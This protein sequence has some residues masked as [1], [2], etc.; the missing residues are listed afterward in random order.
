MASAQ[1][2]SL[3]KMIAKGGRTIICSIHTPSAR[4]FSTFDHVYI[5]AEGQCVYAGL[6]DDVVPFLATLGLNC[7]THYN[8][9]DFGNSVLFLFFNVLFFIRKFFSVFI[10]VLLRNFF[11]KK[12][13]S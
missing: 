12:N 4:I 7:P 13:H 3:L 11:N 6:G 8:P 1:C 10:L 5:M 9:A 2:I